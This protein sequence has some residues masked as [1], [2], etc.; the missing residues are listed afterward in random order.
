ME[1][2]SETERTVLRLIEDGL[3]LTARPYE[4]LGARAGLAETDVIDVIAR[5]KRRGFIKR[6]GLV[7]RHHELGYRANAMV[8]WDAPDEEVCDI[9]RLMATFPFVTLCYR[10]P[11]RLPDWPYNLFCMIHA[12]DRDE[13]RAHV[14]DLVSDLDLTEIPREILFSRRRFK[15]RGARY[16][17]AQDGDT[18]RSA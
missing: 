12:K 4:V 16:C 9:G 8:V 7:V 10:R 11:R 3:P 5:L 15:Q 18:G 13:A 1:R 14:G 17:G 2:L 6:F